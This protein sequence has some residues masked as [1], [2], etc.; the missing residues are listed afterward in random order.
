MS[1]PLEEHRIVDLK[2]MEIDLEFYSRKYNYK[3]ID[4]EIGDM[5]SLST[6]KN[7]VK[8]L[9]NTYDYIHGMILHFK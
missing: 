6:L 5:P 7:I 8:Q 2:N 9:K 1:I 3:S 4:D